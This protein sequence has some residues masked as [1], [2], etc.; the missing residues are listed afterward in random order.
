MTV[1]GFPSLGPPTW[2]ARLTRIGLWIIAAGLVLAV[3]S[4]PLHRFGIADFRVALLTLAVGLLTLVVGTVLATI[5]LLGATARRVQIPRATAAVGIAVGLVVIGYLVSWVARGRSV[6]PIHEVSTDLAEPPAFV[7]VMEIRR[8]AHAVNPPEYVRQVQGPG[9]T[10]D[11]PHMQ[12]LNYP[13]IQPLELAVPPAEAL[14]RAQH[15]AR[16]LGWEIV[17]VVPSE[18]RLE[19]TDST[20]FFG[21]K[22]D[23]V[24]RVRA[25]EAGSRVDARSKSRVGLG[26]VGTNAKRI[27]AFFKQMG[28]G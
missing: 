18:G 21:F 17:A 16:A 25:S 7:A 5:G 13:D 23:V 26:D 24:V 19:A 12:L 22:D 14:D 1:Q 15:A 20:A 11:V 2:P 4:G 6:P 8:R 9:G 10:I 28:N 27:R 3:V